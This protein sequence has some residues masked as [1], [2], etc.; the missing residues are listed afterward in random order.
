VYPGEGYWAPVYWNQAYYN[1]AYWADTSEIQVEF[2]IGVPE[3]KPTRR[4]R[5]SVRQGPPKRQEV[6]RRDS[7]GPWIDLDKRDRERWEQAQRLAAE[8]LQ[9]SLQAAKKAEDEAWLLITAIALAESEE[10]IV[11]YKPSPVD[12]EQEAIQV[13]MALAQL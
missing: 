9:L 3:R 8:T 11:R 12:E 6:Q 5:K 2:G 1:S 13:L 4:G 10:R 7:F